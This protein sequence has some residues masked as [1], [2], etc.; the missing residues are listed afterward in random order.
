[1]KDLTVNRREALG[2]LGAAGA[3]TWMAS[4]T[5]AQTQPHPP[6]VAPVVPHPN[7]KPPRAGVRGWMTGAQAAVEALSLEG[8]RC[9]FGVPGAQNNEFWDAMK[10]AGLPYF[11]ATHEASASV[12]ADGAARATRDV[13]VFSVVPGPGLTN[14]LTG[15]GEA[16]LD[17]IPIVGL[18]TDVV[19]GPDA[20]AFQVHHLPSTPVLRPLC[21]LV[22]EVRHQG[23]I[24]AAIHEAFRV[25][26]SGE[27]G[28]V[29][30]VLPYDLLTESWNYREDV[31]P[32]LP[33]P[34]DERAYHHAL[35]LL[36]NRRLKI[37]LFAGAGC[38]NAT[39][40][41]AA[42][43]E[44]LQAPVATSVSGKG[45]I[46]DNHPLA[47]GWGYG[48]QGTRAAEQ[49]FLDRDVVLAVGVR[50]SEVSTAN[51]HVPP[52]DHVIHVDINPENIG[53]NVETSV[54]V[55]ADA[56][57]FLARLLADADIVRRN[58]DK[59]LLDKIKRERSADRTAHRHVQIVD[60]VDPMFLVH[61]LR[62]AMRFE[63]L[64]YVDV[65][66][67]THWAAEAYEVPAPWLYN[68]PANNQSMGWSI[69]AAI[70]GQVVRPEARVVALVGDGC[71]LMSALE[72]SS[73]AREGLPVKFIV[74]DDGAYHYMQMLQVPLYRRTTAT[75]LAKI[76][77]P[78]FAQAMG[79]GY[80]RIH[81]NAQ[82]PHGLQAAFDYPG[83]VL[84][85]VPIS[86]KGREIRWLSALRESY[87]RKMEPKRL[88]QVGTRAAVRTVT[89]F[90]YND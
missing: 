31:P 48:R 20:P 87:L 68:A 23:Q 55:H 33:P 57:V 6:A 14:S 19:R 4:A 85:H 40:E 72:M 25:A 30:V 65:T 86:Y 62:L 52:H 60:A 28:P 47:V 5:R 3:V 83:P 89:P 59:P 80:L 41:L 13:G 61:H 44:L 58:P 32:P 53:R 50:Y 8:T 70:A 38:A 27:P 43:A 24:P 42:V 90:K 67:S 18:V 16:F 51:Y 11:L 29:A 26:R 78:A 81:S 63:D 9:V 34:F 21:K 74:L 22:V 36:A 37:G 15:V 71:F 54:G 17:G 56:R 66:A 10:E 2:A 46:S 82:V 35:S 64:L 1:M 45:V 84:V 88:A 12:M 77:Y 75:E 7:A 73:A 49:T 69:P 79:L 39:A 76:D